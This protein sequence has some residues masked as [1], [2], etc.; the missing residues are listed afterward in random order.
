[1]LSQCYLD[2]DCPK[3]PILMVHSIINKFYK[4]RQV[5]ITVKNQMHQ[6]YYSMYITTAHMYKQ[7]ELC[8]TTYYACN[9]VSSSLAA[10]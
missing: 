4:R 3:I 8:S 5:P 6:G 1:M 2:A 10:R 9:T 7:N